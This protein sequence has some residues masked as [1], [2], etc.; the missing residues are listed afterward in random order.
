MRDEEPNAAG[1]LQADEVFALATRSSHLWRR[2]C[3]V[4]YEDQRMEEN[5]SAPH[6]IPPDSLGASPKTPAEGLIHSALPRLHSFHYGLIYLCLCAL[7]APH[8]CI[9]RTV[10][11]TK[12]R[13]SVCARVCVLLRS[14]V[15]APG[16]CGDCKG[17]CSRRQF[18]VL[19][20]PGVA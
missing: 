4:V 8:S 10:T 18:E 5:C 14:G 13:Y 16:Y 7:A 2:S 15:T 20:D 6:P 19:N 3:P 9:T 1:G 11:D 12:W 17:R